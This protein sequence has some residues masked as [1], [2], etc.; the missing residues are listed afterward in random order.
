MLRLLRRASLGM[1]LALDAL[2]LGESEAGHLGVNVQRLKL[3][4]VFV[5]SGAVGATVAFTGLIG[6]VGLIAPH[7]VRLLCGPRHRVLVPGAMLTGS[8][9]AV[10]VDTASRTVVAPAELPIG[11]I[12]A[13][14]G[15]PFFLV[16]LYRN[17]MKGV[18]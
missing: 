17:R 2:A 15:G 5:S 10:I 4:A 3:A 14:V 9:L 8:L 16:L 6:F 1:L 11:V 12:S 13:L 18:A 7:I